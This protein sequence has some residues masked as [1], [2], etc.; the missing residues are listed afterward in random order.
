MCLRPH[1]KGQGTRSSRNK[2]GGWA[3]P[4]YSR[5]SLPML[6]FVA[7]VLELALPA[8]QTQD[9][10]SSEVPLASSYVLLQC[11]ADTTGTCASAKRSIC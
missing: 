7:R 5:C 1:V 6:S 2:L 11:A 4:G 3:A 8:E 9:D 10:P